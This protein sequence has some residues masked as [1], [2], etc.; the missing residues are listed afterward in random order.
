MALLQ[1]L[2]DLVIKLSEE[3][4]EPNMQ[5]II[6]K[7]CNYIVNRYSND[8]I[9]NKYVL[10]A[11][12]ERYEK[13][14]GIDKIKEFNSGH[15]FSGMMYDPD[16]FNKFEYWYESNYVTDKDLNDHY[17]DIDKCIR[18][19][20]DSRM[21]VYVISTLLNN[22][23]ETMKDI[24]AVKK[25]YENLDYKHDNYDKEGRIPLTSR[26]FDK[27]NIMT[28]HKIARDFEPIQI[29]EFISK[30]LDFKYN[31]EVNVDLYVGEMDEDLNHD[32]ITLTANNNK[33]MVHALS[34]SLQMCL[35]ELEQHVDTRDIYYDSIL[36]TR[37]LSDYEYQTIDEQLE[38]NAD[39]ALFED[40][41]EELHHDSV[42]GYIY[43]N[44]GMH[45][46]KI[47]FKGTV[48][49]IANFIMFNS[50]SPVVVTDTLD[51]FIVSSTVGGF[52]DR[53]S[54]PDFRNDLLKAIMPLQYGEK[55]PYDPT[56]INDK[57]TEK[58][59]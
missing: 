31:Q 36:S 42:Y 15:I 14:E 20:F 49:N 51:Q 27:A 23:I 38:K 6:D 24:N 40:F 30:E 8:E 21:S 5:N 3:Y 22:G 29:I 1:E 35:N 2:N 53:V 12:K 47:V 37:Y 44:N 7:Y 10:Q 4:N 34:E 19:N 57:N 59:L 33:D 17:S 43:D 32:K 11:E 16:L 50:N 26:E 58:T 25:A 54:D 46:G 9:A 41:Q 52:L 48:E 56:N 39:D 45:N 55:E 28:C 18:D 13:S